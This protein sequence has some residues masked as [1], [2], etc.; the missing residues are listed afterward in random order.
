M[1]LQAKRLKSE[2][3]VS[4]VAP[5][6][7]DA[8]QLSARLGE[9]A[10]DSDQDPAIVGWSSGVRIYGQKLVWGVR[11]PRPIK[12]APSGRYRLRMRKRDVVRLFVRTPLSIRVFALLDNGDHWVPAYEL[13]QGRNERWIQYNS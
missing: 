1:T 9:K 4:P 2:S 7:V 8:T 5:Q 12:G 10:S 11:E 3:G 6:T 13:E